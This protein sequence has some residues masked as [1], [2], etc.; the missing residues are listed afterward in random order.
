MLRT[1]VV[2]SR[3]AAGAALV[4]LGAIGCDG[5]PVNGAGGGGH[6]G[7]EVGGAGGA[8][9]GGGGVGGAGIGG[10]GGGGSGGAAPVACLPTDVSADVLTLN[11]DALCV[12]ARYEANAPLGYIAPTWGKHGGPLFSDKSDVA[13]HA[14]LSRWSAP[15]VPVG[16]M[17]LKVDDLDVMWPAEVDPFLPPYAGPAL[18]LPFGG[19]T[20]IAYSDQFGAA[21]GEAIFV[22]GMNV[23]SRRGT[24]ALF[25]AAAVADRVLYT[26]LSVFGDDA[27]GTNAL[28]A[29][30]RCTNVF[31]SAD[32][33]SCLPVEVAAWGDASG[34]ITTDSAGNAFAV[35][36]SFA[37]DQTARGFAANEVA[38]GAGPSEG[39]D[40]FTVPG[41][42]GS[43]G[44]IAPDGA[45]AGYVVF[46]PSEFDAATMSV[47]AKEVLASRYTSDGAALSSSGAA[48]P[49]V[50]LATP[51]TSVTLLTAPENQLWIGANTDT[52]AVWI[53]VARKPL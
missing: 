14:K 42:G 48:A 6:G 37:G 20:M 7:S 51:G 11:D 34:P 38:K 33:P 39:A 50:T 43:I 53:V 10:A 31:A 52:G 45:T 44:A 41:F 18:D 28:Y 25:G 8:G 46:Q 22:K 40:L 29:A 2:V 23:D 27:P 5:A 26:G 4:M 13:G 15:A 36:T 17:T 19:L 9:G 49:L 24:N 3:G 12:V 47:V 35:M 30:D 32:D 16:D 21:G 1:M